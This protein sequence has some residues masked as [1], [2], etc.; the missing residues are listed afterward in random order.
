MGV[1]R[2]IASFVLHEAQVAAGVGTG[3]G[4]FTWILARKLHRGWRH[5][6]GWGRR[7]LGVAVGAW[8]RVV[9]GGGN[10]GASFV[11]LLVLVCA[12]VV[13]LRRKA[14]TFWRE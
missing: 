11:A 8:E 2:S 1:R 9:A 3:C 10:C 5:L 6:M 12:A 4:I 7:W 13:E 14:C